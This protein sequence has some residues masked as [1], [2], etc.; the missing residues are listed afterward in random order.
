MARSYPRASFGT[1]PRAVNLAEHQ[2]LVFAVAQ[3]DHDC[4]V[5]ADLTILAKLS[6]ANAKTR[7]VA[8]A[9]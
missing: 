4:D 6:C 2:P 9:A 3:L 5:H 1:R 7:A 8:L